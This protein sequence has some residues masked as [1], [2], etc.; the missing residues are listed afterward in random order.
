MF[1]FVHTIPS[2]FSYSLYVYFFLVFQM[3]RMYELCH[4]QGIFIFS[5]SQWGKWATEIWNTLLYDMERDTCTTM[6]G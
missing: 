2:D 6:N 4:E 5:Y 1:H 3:Y